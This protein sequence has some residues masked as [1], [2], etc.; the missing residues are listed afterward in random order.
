MAA[1]KRAAEY[2]IVRAVV[3]L[4]VELTTADIV[5]DSD[6]LVVSQEVRQYDR[7]VG[8]AVGDTIVLV[9]AMNEELVAVAV[10]SETPLKSDAEQAS[11]SW[12]RDAIA[13][14]T[15]T[16]GSAVWSPGD[17]KPTAADVTVVQAGWLLCDG[18]VRL[19][20]AYPPLY[21]AIGDAFNTGGE[22]LSPPALREFRLPDGRGRFL[23][24][25]TV[26]SLG[27]GVGTAPYASSH[28]RGMPAIV[29]AGA[30]QI[31]LTLTQIPSHSHTGATASGLAG[32]TVTG[33][34]TPGVTGSTTPGVTGSSTVTGTTDS[35]HVVLPVAYGGGTGT[36]PGD[37][38]VNAQ[39]AS[40]AGTSVTGYNGT[41]TDHTH[42]FTA[43]G[44]HTHTS[45][46]HTH[47]SAPHTHPI[48]DPGHTHPITA[49]GGGQAHPNLPPFFVGNWLIK[50]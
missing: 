46:P 33:S 1:E 48:T 41:Q 31:A 14:A 36:N 20:S 8:I 23:M 4:E 49:E 37:L 17:L 10:I 24:G 19:C 30:E 16:G 18:T 39:W 29:D 43:E 11:K 15:G 5:I 9:P 32:I 26:A 50:T 28:L 22:V 34:T 27:G 6:E 35:R 45:A 44:P 38:L 25:A 40:A 47:T 13:A 2:G 3:P 12:V 42:T 7:D 21:A